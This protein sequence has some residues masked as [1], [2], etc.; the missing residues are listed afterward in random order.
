[1]QSKRAETSPSKVFG[2]YASIEWGLRDIK[3]LSPHSFS[4]SNGS[5][6]WSFYASI[7]DYDD[8][9]DVELPEFE[10]DYVILFIPNK[11]G[12]NCVLMDK[13]SCNM[14][15]G[16]KVSMKWIA[17]RIKRKWAATYTT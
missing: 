7:S 16:Q 6:T 13:A 9:F 5:E 15:M 10:D 4:A 1:M 2:L 3:F 11:S 14:C 8:N 17:Q 12:D